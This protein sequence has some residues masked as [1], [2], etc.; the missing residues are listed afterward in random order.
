MHMEVTEALVVNASDSKA[1]IRERALDTSDA[2]ALLST[3]LLT[4][5][6]CTAC[7]AV[8]RAPAV[9]SPRANS[10]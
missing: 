7:T 2:N 4:S 3:L 6:I 10:D 5:F 9:I 8:P 1:E